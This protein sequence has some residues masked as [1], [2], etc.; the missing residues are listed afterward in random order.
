LWGSGMV[1]TKAWQGV[2]GVGKW[3]APRLQVSASDCNVYWV[4]TDLVFEQG[5]IL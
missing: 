3:L 4:S 5:G 1:T 2:T